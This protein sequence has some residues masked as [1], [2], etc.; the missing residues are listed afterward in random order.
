ML[1]HSKPSRLR[2]R[3][4]AQIQRE[5]RLAALALAIPGQLEPLLA[6][7]AHVAVALALP[8]V[9][10]RTALADALGEAEG[11]RALGASV[12]VLALKAALLVSN[13]LAELVCRPGR[14]REIGRGERCEGRTSGKA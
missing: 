6:H 7:R 14:R 13:T 1:H 5:C 4:G 11:G 12:A 9:L 3:Q 8:A 10:S 2:F